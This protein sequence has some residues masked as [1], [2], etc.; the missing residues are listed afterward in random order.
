MVTSGAAFLKKQAAVLRPGVE[1]AAK[2]SREVLECAANTS[3]STL[4]S[5]EY[6]AE[7]YRKLAALADSEDKARELLIVCGKEHAFEASNTFL[8][9]IMKVLTPTLL[10]KKLPDVWKRDCTMGNVVAEVYED[11]IRNRY[12]DIGGFDHIAPVAIGFVQFALEAMGKTIT[13]AELHDWSLTTPAPET[14]SFDVH[15]KK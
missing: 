5:A 11:R 13:K 10:A 3:G 6:A 14:F 4:V 15:W 2:L 7:I 12:H 8:R 9:L 1:D